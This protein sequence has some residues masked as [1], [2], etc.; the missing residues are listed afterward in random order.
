MREA[1][2]KGTPV[3]RT[4]FYEF[5]GDERCWEVEEQYMYGDKYLCCP[6]MVE[7]QE[8]MKVYLPKLGMEGRWKKM[9]SE[10]FFEGGRD[11]TVKTPLHEM[12]VFV[13]Q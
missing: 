10:D 7:G 12:P 11:V 8:E 9:R 2:E 5:P 4:L 13:R 3:M 6:V 1:S